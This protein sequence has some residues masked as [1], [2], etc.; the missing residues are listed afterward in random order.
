MER[1]EQHS[2]MKNKRVEEKKKKDAV[3]VLLDL[4]SVPDAGPAPPA[5]DEQQCGNKPCKKKRLQDYKG[6]VMTSGRKTVS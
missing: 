2:R 3:D 6:S 1:Y 5:E 4:S